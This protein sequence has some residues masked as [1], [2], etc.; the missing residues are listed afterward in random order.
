MAATTIYDLYSQH[1]RRLSSRERLRLAALILEELAERDQQEGQQPRLLDLYGAGAHNSVSMDA[2]EYV[3][4][5]RE[6]RDHRP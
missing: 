5:L 3:D 2:Q 4:K 1:I 6:E